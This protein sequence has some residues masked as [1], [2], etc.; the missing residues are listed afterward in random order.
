[1]YDNSKMNQILKWSEKNIMQ[2]S[3]DSRNNL[4]S[5]QI[6]KKENLSKSIVVLKITE[7]KLKNKKYNNKNEKK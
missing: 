2:P 6:I 1:M 4:N 3:N 5:L 7:K